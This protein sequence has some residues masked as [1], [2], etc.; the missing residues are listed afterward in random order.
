MIPATSAAGLTHFVAIKIALSIPAMVWCD[1][2]FAPN[3]WIIAGY[4]GDG[5]DELS[6]WAFA[7]PH[8]AFAFKLQF[9]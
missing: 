1:E 6:V 8:E 7:D 5:T 9:G 3:H 4:V 2:H